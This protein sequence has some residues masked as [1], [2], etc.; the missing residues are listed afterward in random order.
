MVR[1]GKRI[2]ISNIFYSNFKQVNFLNVIFFNK[3]I[4]SKTNL[5]LIF[6][7]ECSSLQLP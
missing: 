6:C 4:M 2:L 1:V 3:F 5:F 7:L